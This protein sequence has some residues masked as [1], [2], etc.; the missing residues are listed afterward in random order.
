MQ[1]GIFSITIP[2]IRKKNTARS[3]LYVLEKFSEQ[4]GD[5][6]LQSITTDEILTFLN[7]LTSGNKQTTKSNR[8]SN[9][10]SFFNFVINTFDT[11]FQNP[12]DTPALRKL[13]KEPKPQ[14][15]PIIEKDVIDEIV[16]RITNPRNR[17]LIE[18]MARGGMRIGEVL[19]LTPRDVQDRKL[20]LREPKSG[21]EAEVVFIPQK[22]ANR[23]NDYIRDKGIESDKRIFPITYSAARSVIVKAGKMLG[24]QMRPHDLRRHSASYASRSGTPIEIVSKVIL[25]HAN[26]STPQRYLGKI[27]DTEAIRWIENLYG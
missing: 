2:P 8:Y 15:W 14:A 13:F 19:K 18:L 20:Y 3:H 5:R 16:F 1:P 4:Y 17:L 21:R 10:R 11:Q 24:I 27:S 26:L 12:C 25:R 7:Q 23:L 22:L 9:L 6:E